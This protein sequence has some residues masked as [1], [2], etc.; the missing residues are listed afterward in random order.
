VQDLELAGG[1]LEAHVVDVGLIQVGAHRD[2][3]EARGLLE[4][5]H[6]GAAVPAHGRLDD[7]DQLLGV[8]GLGDPRVGPEAQTAHPLGDGGRARADDHRQAR[9]ARAHLLQIA[10]TVGTEDRQVD[11][12][13]VEAHRHEA[14][15]AHRCGQRPVL[16]A[17]GVQAL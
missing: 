4:G 2:L 17:E 14:L 13:S 11:D 1:Q 16:A 6:L 15:G 10:P 12:E 8:A 5:G 7:A 3:A 9:L